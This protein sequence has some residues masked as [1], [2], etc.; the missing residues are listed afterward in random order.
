MSY[1]RLVSIALIGYCVVAFHA[2]AVSDTVT[3]RTVFGSDTTPPSIPTNVVA[4]PVAT[5]QINVSW[6]SSTDAMSTVAYQVFRDALQI[7]TATTATYVDTGLTAETLYTYFIRAFDTSNNI[8]SSSASV[9]TTTLAVATTTSSSGGGGGS[10]TTLQPIPIVLTALEIIPMQDA[11]R[12]RYETQGYVR[13]TVHWGETASYELGSIAAHSYSK[14]HETVITGL[15]PNTPY[16]FTIH[17]VNK[18]GAHGVLTTSTFT[19]L[20]LDIQYPPTNVRN[21]RVHRDGPHLIIQWDIPPGSAIEKVR[22]LRNDR[23]YPS[24]AADGWLV[25]EGAS[26]MAIDAQRGQTTEV[27]YY[28]VFAYDAAGNVS[29]GALTAYV[30][31]HI[32]EDTEILIPSATPTVPIAQQI[33]LSFDTLSFI[34]DGHAIHAD[35]A[36]IPIDGAKQLIVSMPA[37]AV[38]QH[39]KSIVVTLYDATDS[40]QR[41]AFLLRANAEKDAY[42]AVLAPLG[43]AGVFPFVVSLYDYK[44]Q[45]R[46]TLTGTLRATISFPSVTETSE[47]VWALLIERFGFLFWN[48]FPWFVLLLIILLLIARTL[49]KSAR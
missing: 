19:T 31:P 16:A 1:A 41:F 49:I 11:V 17:G 32:P 34:Q 20:P 5:S 43:T 40:T 48:L 28:G 13:P 14:T 33:P 46:G 30:P 29:S 37:D 15:T 7:A 27:Q 25:H 4:V 3:V 22:V 36:T 47:G 8:S 9:A 35:D 24:D 45:Q 18:V 39:L 23:F 42:V 44:T 21:V 2:H 10:S 26:T 6:S 38:P 12:I